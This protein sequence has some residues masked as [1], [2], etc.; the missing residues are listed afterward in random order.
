M[1]SLFSTA[2]VTV[3]GYGLIMG[4]GCFVFQAPLTQLLGARE[5]AASYLRDY[6]AGYAPGIPFLGATSAMM[7]FLP[8]NNELKK[9][10]V[11]MGIMVASN[12]AL[13]F[14]QVTALKMGTLGMGL[15]TTVSYIIST[16]VMV[17]DFL[18]KEKAYR[19]QWKLVSFRNMRE[20]I[21]L[22]LPELL[23][24]TGVTARSYLL[25]LT[26]MGS[27]GA[28]GIAALNVE[29]TLLSFLGAIPQG[30]G[31]AFTL[32]GSIYY[33]ER[34]RRSLKTLTAFSL[35]TGLLIS[36]LVTALLM[37]GSGVIGRLLFPAGGEEGRLARQMLLCFSTTFIFNTVFSLWVRLLQIEDHMKIV[38]AMNF[39]E[40]VYIAAV[41]IGGLQ[42]IGVMGVWLSQPLAEVLCLLT[43][44][45][46]IGI[47]LGHSPRRLEEWMKLPADFGAKDE[48]VLEYTVNSMEEVT[49]I[50]E[51]IMVFLENRGI[52]TRTR[53][54]VGL[55]VE[56]MA[57]NVI[58]YGTADGKR[59]TVEIRLVAEDPL[60]V[61]VRDDCMSFDP[62]QW[63]DQFEPE[64]PSKNVGIRMITRL[65]TEMDYHNDAGINT[66][67]MKT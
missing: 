27:I 22:G 51:K 59:H 19:F 29:N 60:V 25:N 63:L 56:E 10:Y 43:I 23:F 3:T 31:G 20:T 55:S 13:D 15:A 58:R 26:V 34:D 38:N 48:N 24:N 45:I 61:R 4:I 54:V 40:Q 49:T 21:R 44:G 11:V 6:M 41:A 7:T 17:P 18:K 42:L 30:V 16:A 57:G 53:T 33:G 14:L 28:A 50:S 1:I 62:K 47:R 46:W 2:L 35:K 64:D 66:L 9:S 5:E 8:C 39:M 36:S 12:T 65:T 32:L 52:G 37:I 67:L